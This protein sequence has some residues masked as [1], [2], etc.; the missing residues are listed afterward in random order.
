MAETQWIQVDWQFLQTWSGSMG[1]IISGEGTYVLVKGS[2]EV[3]LNRSRASAWAP[4]PKR[5]YLLPGNQEAAGKRYSARV[6]RE[7]GADFPRTEQDQK[8]RVP[9]RPLQTVLL[10]R[11]KISRSTWAR[12][13][14]KRGIGFQSARWYD[15]SHTDLAERGLRVGLPKFR[16]MW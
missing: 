3:R 15:K 11:K 7:F 14:L 16:D 5:F 1:L 4:V 12:K 13:V 8:N 6:Q 10:A 9:Y 2:P